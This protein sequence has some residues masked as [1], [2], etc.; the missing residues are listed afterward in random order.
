[1]SRWVRLTAAQRMELDEELHPF[2]LTPEIRLLLEAHL[3][4][5]RDRDHPR[6][7]AHLRAL[8]DAGRRLLELVAR[9]PRVTDEAM[10]AAV[11]KGQIE[12]WEAAIPGRTGRPTAQARRELLERA[13]GVLD[14][15]GFT[16]KRISQYREGPRVLALQVVLR[17]ADHLDGR[18]QTRGSLRLIR[19]VLRDVDRRQRANVDRVIAQNLAEMR[20]IQEA[21][22]GRFKTPDER[23]RFRR[24]HERIE[25]M[26]RAI[27][28]RGT[29][30]RR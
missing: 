8:T 28:T 14:D 29:K 18:P 23:A 13:A 6:T 15:A 4:T 7:A 2:R 1:M 16:W 10:L 11:L 22:T 30:A 25:S 3:T 19:D 17:I 9:A 24:A 5:Y 27:R 21:A 12:Q 26:E 20:E